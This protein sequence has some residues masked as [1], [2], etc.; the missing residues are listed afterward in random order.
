MK[1]EKCKWKYGKQAP[2]MFMI[3]DFANKYMIDKL[4]GDY[5]GADWGGRCKKTHSLYKFLERE[6]F[7]DFPYVKMTLFLVVGR[8]EAFIANGKPSVSRRID[9]NPEFATFLRELAE[10][11]RFEVAYHGYTHGKLLEKYLTQEWLTFSSLEEANQT[12]EK[13]K[14]LYYG[15]TGKK[16][17]G[18]KYCGYESN[19][20]SDESISQSGFE[21]WCRHWDANILTHH[22]TGVENLELEMFGE[23]CVDIPSTVDG[24]LLSLRCI[25]QFASRNYLRALYYLFKYG[26]TIER[27]L[28]RLARNGQVINIQEHSSPMREDEKHQMPNLVDDIGNIRY[29]LR[30]LKKYDLWYATGHEIVEYWKTYQNTSVLLEG[31][32]VI[33]TVEKPELIGKTLWITLSEQKNGGKDICLKSETGTVVE[34]VK[35]K[36]EILFEIT[37]KQVQE[38]FL[39]VQ[40]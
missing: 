24:S 13:S 15:V 18:G 17:Y 1:V 38:H 20:F 25:S 7:L 6:I 37:L 32:Y 8:R 31:G 11:E 5:V 36:D 26:L 39:P 16:F 21:W 34:G 3:D 40:K 4:D 23:R 35:C 30:Y 22:N 14:G 12:I 33:V 2:V 29:M 19:E 28:D 10:D 9:E 27:I